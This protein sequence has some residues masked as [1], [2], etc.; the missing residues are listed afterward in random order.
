MSNLSDLSWGTKGMDSAKDLGGAN[1]QTKKD[2][3]TVVE[4]KLGPQEKEDREELWQS[5]RTELATPK[6]EAKSHRDAAAKL[7]DHV[8]KAATSMSAGRYLR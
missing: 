1:A 8:R 3:K 4:V 5:M 2:G 6:V 7:D